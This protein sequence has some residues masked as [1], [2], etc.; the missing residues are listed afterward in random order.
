MALFRFAAVAA[1]MFLLIQQSADAFLPRERVVYHAQTKIVASSSGSNNNSE[2]PTKSF[3]A[4]VADTVQNFLTNS[5]LNEGKKALVRSLAG[6]YDQAAIQAKLNGFITEKPVLML[7]FRRC[8][9]CIRAKSILDEK[10]ARYHVVEL[11]EV[12]DGKALRAEMSGIVG[13]TS[14]PAIWIAGDF[15]G[16]CNDGPKGGIVKIYESGE[17]DSM[18]KAAG[19]V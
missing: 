19:A 17:L 4:G 3:V 16:G 5:P 1:A 13:R 14:V 10:K 7:S 8:P 18:L 11:D 2:D 15:I 9:F 6:E 12:E